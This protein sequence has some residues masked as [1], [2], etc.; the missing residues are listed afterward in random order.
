[1]DVGSLIAKEQR[2]RIWSITPIVA[3]LLLGISFGTFKNYKATNL[4]DQEKRYQMIPQMESTL[5]E[6]ESFIQEFVTYNGN[7]VGLGDELIA[8]AAKIAEKEHFNLTST[9]VKTRPILLDSSTLE[10]EATIEGTGTLTSL[11]KFMDTLLIQQRLLSEKAVSL[12]LLPDKP[13]RYSAKFIFSR[14]ALQKEKNA[15]E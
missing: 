8:A 11:I 5:H 13:G 12:S 7:G 14:I 6:S 10:L 15:Y 2:M 9:E 4:A 1:M 3:I